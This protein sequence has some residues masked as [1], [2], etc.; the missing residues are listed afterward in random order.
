MST[1]RTADLHLTR[2]GRLLLHGLPMMILATLVTA[3]AVFFGS[4][5]LTPAAASSSTSTTTVETHVVGYGETLWSIAAEVDPTADRSEVIEQIG[6]LN[7]LDNS[8]LEPGQ[9]LYL[10]AGH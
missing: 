9:V 3:V 4:T 7:S 2:R 8:G 1:T 5:A 6:A 10:P